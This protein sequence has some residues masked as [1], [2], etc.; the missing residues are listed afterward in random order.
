MCGYDVGRKVTRASAVSR[1][2][3]P[4][5]EGKSV[6]KRSEKERKGESTIPPHYNA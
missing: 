5:L 4:S 2:G 3:E 6:G 1:T